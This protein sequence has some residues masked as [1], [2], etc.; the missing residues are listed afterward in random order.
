MPIN[1][2]LSNLS[3]HLLGCESKLTPPSN[4]IILN[5]YIEF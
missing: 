4:I 3:N 1:G 2:G 5:D